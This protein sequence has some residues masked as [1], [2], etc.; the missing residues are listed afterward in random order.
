MSFLW[1]TL[2][3]LIAFSIL[4]GV[5]EYGHFWAARK[6][7]IKVHRFSIGVGKVFWSRKSKQGTEIAL[8]VIP[9]GGYVSMLDERNEDVPDELKAQAFNNKTV[10][11][12]A[13]VIA[14]GPAANFLFAILAY[15]VIYL[16][17]IPSL[18]PVVAEVLP[19]SIAA[20]AKIE[21]NMQI[22][23]V[24]GIR[25]PDW[26]TVNIVLATKLGSAE[27]TITVTDFGEN[28][29]QSKKLDL[30]NWT[31]EPQKESAFSTLGIKP[32]SSKVEMKI[33]KVLEN[34]PAAKAGLQIADQ[35]YYAD[36]SDIKWVDFVTAIQTGEPVSLQ[37]ERAGNFFNVVLKPELNK[38][39]KWFVGISPTFE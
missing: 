30:T 23:A 17:G 7:G 24:D 9:L 25:T 1:S 35:L 22:V 13:F 32:V 20:Q 19:D 4:V 29:E 38:D 34:S 37:I 16:I 28:I 8:S 12:R 5:H 31:F 15:W 26:E 27:T 21:P 14:A 11:Q 33:S 39:G 3:F 10:L 18:K 36:K 6:C 2:S